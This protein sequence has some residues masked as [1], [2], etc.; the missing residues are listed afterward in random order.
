MI[1]IKKGTIEERIIRTVQKEYPITL[2]ELSKKLGVSEK[3][4]MAELIKMQAK[5]ILV[6][7]KLPDKI[8]IRLIRFDF[9]FV[10]RRTQ[11]KFI[12]KKKEEKEKKEKEKKEKKDKEKKEK[13]EDKD[14]IMY[15]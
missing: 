9:L 2:K 8:Y 15:A 13:K 4:L 3:R 14:N 12:K 10:G 6:M 1:E 5:N 7:E 11:Y